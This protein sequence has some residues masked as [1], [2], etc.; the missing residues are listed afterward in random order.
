S[1]KISVIDHC[2]DYDAFFESKENNTV[3]TFFGLKPKPTS[4]DSEP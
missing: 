2:Q 4:R 3:S 1:V